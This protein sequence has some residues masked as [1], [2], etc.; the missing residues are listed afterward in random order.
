M[1]KIS[2]SKKNAAASFGHLYP[3]T[4]FVADAGNIINDPQIELVV[5]GTPNDLHFPLAK[6]ALQAG[7]HVLLEKPFTIYTSEADELIGLAKEKTWCSPSIKTAGSTV[8]TSPS[9]K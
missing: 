9:K 8:P 3:N 6:Q 2:T 4:A 7:K 1:S 5:I